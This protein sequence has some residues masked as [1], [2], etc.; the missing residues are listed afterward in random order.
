MMM[1]VVDGGNCIGQ[2]CTVFC[3]NFPYYH[4]ENIYLNLIAHV[5]ASFTSDSKVFLSR[6]QESNQFFYVMIIL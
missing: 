4:H 2:K 6:G 1:V 5:C 3:Q